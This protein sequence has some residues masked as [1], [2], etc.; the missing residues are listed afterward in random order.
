MNYAKSYATKQ[1]R[2]GG[3]DECISNRPNITDIKGGYMPKIKIDAAD[4][5]FSIW[6]RLRDMEC[7]KCH[8]SVRLNDKGQWS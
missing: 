3:S 4:K 8:S 2:S 6:I 7:V 1:I 5:A